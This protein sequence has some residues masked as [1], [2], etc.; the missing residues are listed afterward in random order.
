M[1]SGLVEDLLSPLLN[2]VSEGLPTH[3]FYSYPFR[4]ASGVLK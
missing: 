1:Q 4:G 3:A 2:P